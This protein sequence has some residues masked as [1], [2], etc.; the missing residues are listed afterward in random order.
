MQSAFV[1]QTVLDLHSSMSE[2]RINLS[3]WAFATILTR[4]VTSALDTSVALESLL[5]LAHVVS[6]EVAALRVLHALG[7]VLGDL[8]LVNVCE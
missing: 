2:K 4:D 1:P 7:S 5:T 6:G 8:A 3:T